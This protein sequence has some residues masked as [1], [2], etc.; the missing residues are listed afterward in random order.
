[1]KLTEP[2]KNILSIVVEAT[3]KTKGK[4]KGDLKDV[5]S[6]ESFDGC[7]FGPLVHLGLVEYHDGVFG[8]GFVATRKGAS[9]I[10]SL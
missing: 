2:Q 5:I 1:M 8:G 7:S 6:S 9:L 4:N 10:L 3:V